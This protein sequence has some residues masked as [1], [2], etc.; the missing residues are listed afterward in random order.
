MNAVHIANVVH[1]PTPTP[2]KK[3]KRAARREAT[4]ERIVD[5]ALLVLTE[6]GEG[7]L[8]MQR[9]ADELGYAIGAFY[10]Y[11]SSKDAL[12]LAVQRRVLELL[13]ADLA[14][15]DARAQEHL[16]RSRALTPEA[17]ALTRLLV[18]AR[19]YQTLVTR[20]PAHFALLSRWLADPAPLVA[21]ESALPLL[22][23][24]FELFR[25][26]PALF[27]EAEA[28]GALA[29]G[30]AERRTF[31]LWSAM[32]GAMQLRKLARFG[33]PALAPEALGAEAVRALLIGWGAREEHLAD[34]WRRAQKLVPEE[35]E[36]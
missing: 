5:T 20:R 7:A 10:R 2:A 13:A 25:A 18:A 19:A 29:S 16:E 31:V 35:E 32:Q 17:A 8:T 15:A 12:V 23:A 11:F 6:E 33:L 26:I 30:D 21:T 4:V 34:A 22:P 27:R 1:E 24:L 36:S 14:A 9:L 28:R 3:P